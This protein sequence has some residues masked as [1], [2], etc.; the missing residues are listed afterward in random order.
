MKIFSILLSFFVTSVVFGQARISGGVYISGTIPEEY[1]IQ[2]KAD[3]DAQQLEIQR[4]ESQTKIASV[5]EKANSATGYVIKLSTKNGGRLVNTM[6]PSQS[7]PYL[8]SYD[9]APFTEV[10]SV[11]S[12]VKRVPSLANPIIYESPIRISFRGKPTAAVGTY[13]DT[14][15][16]QISAP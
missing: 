2:V 4:G 6:L 12:I 7:V 11:E 15:Y 9:K 3:P 16:L 1:S 8:I 5:I 10:S 13:A 14:L